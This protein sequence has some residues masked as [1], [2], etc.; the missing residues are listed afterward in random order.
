MFSLVMFMERAEWTEHAACRDLDPAIFYPTPLAARGNR[1]VIS[2]RTRRLIADAK[3][4]CRRCD[5]QAECLAFAMNNDEPDG[6]WGG[7]TADERR[8]LV[9]A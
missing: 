6:V 5:V 9:A 2:P 3:A 8:Q 7:L 1:V 4:V